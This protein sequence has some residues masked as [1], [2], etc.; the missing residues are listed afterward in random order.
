ME[1]R[2]CFLLVALVCLL[3]ACNGGAPSNQPA[4]KYVAAAESGGGGKTVTLELN[5]GGEGSW[6]TDVDSVP[7]KW[8]VRGKTAIL[9]TKAG[10]VIEAVIEDDGLR[11]DLPGVGR[12]IFVKAPK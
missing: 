4:G 8:D 5:E 1:K 9:H 11:V 12:L 10:G 2:I 3:V 7:F 6:S